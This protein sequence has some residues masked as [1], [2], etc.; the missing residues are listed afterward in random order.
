MFNDFSL[1]LIITIAYT[2]IR[3]YSLW[4]IS[5]DLKTSLMLLIQLTET[6]YRDHSVYVTY[7]N[8]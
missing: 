6:R 5:M 8:A 2:C 1:K 3:T 4:I 7:R